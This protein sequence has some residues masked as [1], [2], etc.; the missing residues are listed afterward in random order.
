MLLKMK[1]G[2]IDCYPVTFG[3]S[4]KKGKEKYSD[5]KNKIIRTIKEKHSEVRIE[6]DFNVLIILYIQRDR[7][8]I[9][10]TKNGKESR[11]DLDNFLKPIIDALHESKLFETESQI[12]EITIQRKIDEEQG[13]E[14][15][16][17]K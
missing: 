6:G 5:F 2:K 16:I 3:A 10:N 14:I 4:D 7:I 15:E 17:F 9:I 11:N 8:K 1:I 13:I 12:K